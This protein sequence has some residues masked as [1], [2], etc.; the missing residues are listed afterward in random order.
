[1]E[2]QVYIIEDFMSLEDCK[3]FYNMVLNNAMEDP[4]DHFQSVGVIHREMLDND[5]YPTDKDPEKKLLKIINKIKDY[6]ESTYEMYG[7]FGFSRLFGHVM[8]P[9]AL[10]VPHRDSEPNEEGIYDGKRRSHVCSILL[11][12][13]Y[14]GGNLVF[15]DQGLTVKPKPGSLVLFPGYYVTH[16]VTEVFSGPRVNLIFFF[17]DVLP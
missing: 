7:Q 15:P 6:Y 10:L 2:R 12:D 9:G 11:T 14:E 1:M 3:Y 4:R 16:S 17:Y 5:D 13:D 8:E